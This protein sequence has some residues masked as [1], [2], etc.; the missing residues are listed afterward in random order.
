MRPT[1][2]PVKHGSSEHLVPDLVGIPRIL[3]DDESPIMLF[4]Q[5]TSWRSTETSRI[6][7]STVRS[8]QFDKDRAQDSDSP[9]CSRDFVFWVFVH[10]AR[11]VSSDDWLLVG[12]GLVVDEAYSSA[13]RLV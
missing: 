1:L 5:P 13:R 10:R 2:S 6:A 11:D 3:T 7:D 12:V 4:N 9:G 8:G